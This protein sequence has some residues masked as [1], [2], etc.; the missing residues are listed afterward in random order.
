M[1]NFLKNP[2]RWQFFPL[3]T[4]FGEIDLQSVTYYLIGGPLTNNYYRW[5]VVFLR[6]SLSS[7]WQLQSKILSPSNRN[8][9]VCSSRNRITELYKINRKRFR[10]LDRTRGLRPIFLFFLS[11]FSCHVAVLSCQ[12]TLQASSIVS[13][14]LSMS[15]Q[16]WQDSF[17][18]K[19]HHIGIYNTLY[20][21]YTSLW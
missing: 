3:C 4:K 18:F 7:R 6:T 10:C 16:M 12:L 8:G 9:F 14:E 19:P 5:G 15:E 17:H 20:L 21:F 11:H 13:S 1:A 2:V